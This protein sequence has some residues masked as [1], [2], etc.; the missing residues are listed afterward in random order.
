[1]SELNELDALEAADKALTKLACENAR[2]VKELSRLR[3]RLP[4]TRNESIVLQAATDAKLLLH[5]R[6]A[7]FDISRRRLAVMGLVSEFHY[8]WA[9]AMLRAARVI[10]TDVSTLPGL[11][12]AIDR[13]DQKVTFLMEDAQSNNKLRILRGYAGKR[14]HHNRY[15]R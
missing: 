1:M 14:Y 3:E 2:L 6:H 15:M 13:I 4:P 12:A 9:L 5:L 11:A 8:G 7:N 10:E